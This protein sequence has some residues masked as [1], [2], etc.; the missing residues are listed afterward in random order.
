VKSVIIIAIAFV[1]LIPIPI[2]AESCI[3]NQGLVSI[4]SGE[5]NAVDSTGNN[6]GTLFNGVH[7]MTGK[8]GNAFHL[9][10]EDDYVD[11]GSLGINSPKDSFSILTWINPDEIT[12]K[13]KSEHTIVGQGQGHPG[14]NHGKFFAELNVI[15]NNS[16]TMNI[17]STQSWVFQ[18]MAK[19]VLVLNEWTF[20]AITYNGSK[21]PDGIKLYIN[22]VQ[23][24][25]NFDNFLHKPDAIPRDDWFIGA[26]GSAEGPRN[27][28]AGLIDEVQI[29]NRVLMPNEISLEYL[30]GETGDCFVKNNELK[31]LKTISEQIT[32]NSEK[33]P[34]RDINFFGNNLPIVIMVILIGVIT[35]MIL[36]KY[37]RIKNS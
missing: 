8:I 11:L 25:H 21:S 35:T 24:Q 6:N 17:G 23:T 29:Y 30:K 28:F 34:N 1:L 19:N 15:Q 37:N 31:N 33:V 22:G 10:G 7:F 9:D 32:L 12:L 36:F 27:F 18:S 20:I 2:F 4:W 16:I 14:S 3:S 5:N 26:H 13:E